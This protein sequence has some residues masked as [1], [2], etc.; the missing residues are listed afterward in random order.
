MSARPTLE[1]WRTGITFIEP[2]VIRYRGTPIDD[3][4]DSWS[5]PATVWLL[6]AGGVPD[7]GQEDAVRRVL[8]AACD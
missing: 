1:S 6:L 2:D 3:V 8:V 4:I 7:A 5:F